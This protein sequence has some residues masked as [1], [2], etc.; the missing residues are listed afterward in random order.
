VIGALVRLLRPWQWTKNLI[1]LA[2]IVF[3]HRLGAPDDARR[4]LLATV[5]LCLLSSAGYVVNDLRDRERDRLHPRKQ[6]RPIASG[7]VSPATATVLAILLAAGGLALARAL[8]PQ[9][10]LVALAY[11]ALSL[12]YSFLLKRI[13]LL[14]VIT[15]ALGFVLRAVAGVAALQPPPQLSPWL[16]V[17][18]FFLA[19][20]LAVGKRRHERLTLS[21]EAARH[22][23][24]LT[25][26]SPQ[27]LDQLVPVVTGSTIL[28]Y[29]IYT[30]SPA[31]AEHAP[32]TRMVLTIPFVT[33]GIFRYLYLVYHKGKGG[34]PSE[35]LLR[36]APLL[37]DIALW[38]LVV[39]GLLYFD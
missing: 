1:A 25:E 20:F 10:A 8:G 29:A 38:G 19:L 11:F 13:V 5:V 32:S 30:I 9:L 15:I 36:D 28:A 7:R 35:L 34:A 33:Y 26:Y 18:T 12:L 3:A 21:E 22:R 16:L 4:A 39:V 6:N 23:V 2:G 14:D 24:T 31:T 27:L 17:C 37:I